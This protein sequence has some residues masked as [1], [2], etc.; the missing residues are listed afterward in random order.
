M[1]KGARVRAMRDR[2][3]LLENREA[4]RVLHR[5]TGRSVNREDKP[6][7]TRR[8]NPGGPK[9][10]EPCPVETC[11][12]AGPWSE[13]PCLTKSGEPAKKAHKGREL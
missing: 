9:V 11:R 7:V 1:S 5:I 3:E 10:Y 2:V 4:T 6:R 13:N 8:S 12:Q